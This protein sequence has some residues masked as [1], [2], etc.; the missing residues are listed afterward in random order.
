MRKLT[1]AEQVREFLAQRKAFRD[2]QGRQAAFIAE[3]GRDFHEMT[4]GQ[5]T[6]GGRSLAPTPLQ[7]GLDAGH[8]G[9]PFDGFSFGKGPFQ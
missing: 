6:V 3:A 2:R 9:G 4:F 1:Q 7:S 5:I 8:G